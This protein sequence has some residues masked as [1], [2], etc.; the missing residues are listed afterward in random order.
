MIPKLIMCQYFLLSTRFK[1]NFKDVFVMFFDTSKQG[2][3]CDCDRSVT[4]TWIKRHAH[5][6]DIALLYHILSYLCISSHIFRTAGVGLRQNMQSFIRKK[7]IICYCWFHHI[8]VTQTFVT[9]SCCMQGWFDFVSVTPAAG[10]LRSELITSTKGR[11]HT[12]VR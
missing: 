8:S 3:C 9:K 6:S 7:K 12:E 5:R 11:A 4:C 10:N 1:N 2:K